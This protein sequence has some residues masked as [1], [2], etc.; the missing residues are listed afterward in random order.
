MDR[1]SDRMTT[2]ILILGGTSE[3]S[4][5]ARALADDA[6][7]DALMSFAGRVRDIAEP[8]IPHRIGGFGG[9]EGLARFIDVNAIDALVDATHPFAA[10]MS[11]NAVAA[12]AEAGV[13][14]L[15]FERPAWT[16]RT[17]DRW[18]EVADMG[19][20]AKALGAA[21]RRVFLTV[22]KLEIAAFH[23]A[24]GH[25]YLIRAIDA[26]DPGLPLA[27]VIAARGPFTVEDERALLRG[28]RIDVV[29]TKNSGAAA[30]AAKIEAARDLG[31]EVVMVTRPQL[32]PAEAVQSVGDAMEW[33]RRLHA[34]T[35]ARRGE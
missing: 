28:E 8:A 18:T 32:P 20:A 7:F 30:T 10:Q 6:R 4:A 13:P 29:V 35:P 17:G 26:F 3:A 22:G 31:I 11:A 1:S 15:R 21:Q 5:L 34:G 16:R 27:R 25:D 23:A 19:Q 14:L 9:A 33:L 24:P 12:A 2:K